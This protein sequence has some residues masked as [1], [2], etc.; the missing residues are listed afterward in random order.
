MEVVCFVV[1]TTHFLMIKTLIHSTIHL[2]PT[3]PRMNHVLVLIV[4]IFWIRHLF[5]YG[6]HARGVEEIFSMDFVRV[7]LLKIT[8]HSTT[9]LIRNFPIILKMILIFPLLTFMSNNHRASMVIRFNTH[10]ISVTV[11]DRLAMLIMS[12]IHVII[13]K[14]L[15]LMSKL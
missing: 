6:V 3:I 14:V 13:L 9:I 7:V 1:L 12:R 8:I 15:T 11:G 4:E 2:N 5:V 10:P